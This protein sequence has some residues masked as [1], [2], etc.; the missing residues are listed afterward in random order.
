MSKKVLFIIFMVIVVIAVVFVCYINQNKEKEVSSNVSYSKSENEKVKNEVDDSQ[1]KE[2][3][4][5]DVANKEIPKKEQNGTAGSNIP[6]KDNEEEAEYQIKVAMQYK[7]EELY[8]DDVFD[9]RIYVE[10]IYTAEEEKEISA[11]KEMNLDE[12]EIAFVVRYEIKSAPGADVNQFLI[13]NGEY[14]EESE[15]V[16]GITRVGVLRPNNSGEQ[17]YKITN[18]GTGF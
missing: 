4:E 2:E 9:A 14:D 15:W 11:L 12:N 8:G 1:I 7:L 16:T 10:K 17:E 13:P 18:F 6:L 3:E 5:K